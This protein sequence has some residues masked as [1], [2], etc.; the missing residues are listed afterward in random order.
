MPSHYQAML[1]NVGMGWLVH[2]DHFLGQLI[3]FRREI[4]EMQ[5][6][7]A[8]TMMGTATTPRST[9]LPSWWSMFG[10]IASKCAAL[11]PRLNP[12]RL[13]P[14]R[15]VTF[16]AIDLNEELG[17]MGALG[18]RFK[19]G[20]QNSVSVAQHLNL[21]RVTSL[22]LLNT[23]IT[24]SS[25]S[26]TLMATRNFSRMLFADFPFLAT[27]RTHDPNCPRPSA[28]SCPFSSIGKDT[29]QSG[30]SLEKPNAILQENE[31]DCQPLQSR[32][33]PTG[34][35]S[36]GSIEKQFASVVLGSN[37]ALLG[38]IP[39]GCATT[40]A[41]FDKAE[42]DFPILIA[43]NGGPAFDLNVV[44]CSL[45]HGN[46]YFNDIQDGLFPAG[47]VI[48][49]GTDSR[50]IAG[51]SWPRRLHRRVNSWCLGKGSHADA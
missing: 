19:G 3:I 34:L 32:V 46:D 47:D 50:D 48:H 20:P 17:S 4:S 42:Q 21:S 35:P 41:I 10:A 30:V 16:G 24:A 6:S 45:T 14:S 29:R 8:K 38:I 25:T 49:D 26:P 7:I 13:A 36:L 31:A 44:A 28:H 18:P 27:I 40:R 2:P 5:P 43:R 15:A 33:F 23:A 51:G 12:F 1:K 37:G 39:E 11:K 22:A 9:F